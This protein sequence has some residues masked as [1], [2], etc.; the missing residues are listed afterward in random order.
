MMRGLVEAV[1]RQTCAIST[2]LPTVLLTPDSSRQAPH[3]VG[4]PAGK[5]G[6]PAGHRHES[7]YQCTPPTPP[8]QPEKFAIYPVGGGVNE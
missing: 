8:C 7:R 3:H 5:R 6:I 1:R 4:R 2:S